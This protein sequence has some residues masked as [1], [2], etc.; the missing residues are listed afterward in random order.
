LY[1]FIN[2]SKKG[3]ESR[4]EKEAGILMRPFLENGGDP[5]SNLGRGVYTIAII[6]CCNSVKFSFDPIFLKFRN[7]YKVKH[8][9]R[10]V[11]F[12]LKMALK[13]NKLKQYREKNK[14]TQEYLANKTN[15]T[16]QTII[17][18]ENGKYIPSLPLALNFAQIFKCKVE[19]LF[20]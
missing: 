4:R 17:S 10:K 1:V 3:A 13:K 19:D 2:S 14:M 20:G 6:G 9:I 12:T 8:T 18:I 16:R 5:S 15:V 11:Y 7:I